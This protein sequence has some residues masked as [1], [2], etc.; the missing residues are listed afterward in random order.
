MIQTLTHGQLLMI[1]GFITSPLIEGYYSCFMILTSLFTPKSGENLQY[2][3]HIMSKYL[4]FGWG[5]ML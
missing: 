2:G 3:K 5:A 1:R 4:L